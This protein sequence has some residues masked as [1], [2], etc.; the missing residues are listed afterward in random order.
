MTWK[1][2]LFVSAIAALNVVVVIEFV[3][4][5]KLAENFALLW[6]GV[7]LLGIVLSIARPLIDEIADDVGVRYGPTL[8]FTGA[9]VFLLFVC[10]NLSMHVS[11]LTE[12]SELLAEELTLL[13]DRL[14]QVEQVE[15][16]ES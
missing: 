4:R 2:V 5:R 16:V 15:R 14:E 8:I 11:R 6:I 7:G 9:V 12:R 13:R 3:R 1:L 10:M